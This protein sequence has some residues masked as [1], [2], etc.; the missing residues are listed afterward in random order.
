MTTTTTPDLDTAAAAI[1]ADAIA[2][3]RD[4]FPDTNP[5]RLALILARELVAPPPRARQQ[6]APAFL[7]SAG[8]L[9]SWEILGR[10]LL[11]SFSL[12]G[13]HGDINLLA[14]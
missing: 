13:T 6:K 4:Q 10:T 7:E 12:G 14:Q 9:A 8:A 5:S 3:L 2:Q 11:V 1:A